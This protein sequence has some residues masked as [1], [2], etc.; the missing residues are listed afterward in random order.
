MSVPEVRSARRPSPGS[1]GCSWDRS[2]TSHSAY[3]GSDGGRAA[4]RAAGAVRYP[5]H[6][7][8]GRSV[9][10][11]QRRRGADVVRIDGLPGISRDLPGWMLD[12]E[13]CAAMQPGPPRVS[14]AALLELHIALS[15]FAVAQASASEVGSVPKEDRSHE[16]NVEAARKVPPSI[17]VRAA[18]GD[19]EDGSRVRDGGSHRRRARRSAAGGGSCESKGT[20]GWR[21]GR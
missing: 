15:S 19:T 9:I 21:T 2:N 10:V 14:V 5:W 4:W 20:Q 6:P 8:F 3:K 18:S 16:G 17:I 11:V 1:D 12:A 7:L 13:A